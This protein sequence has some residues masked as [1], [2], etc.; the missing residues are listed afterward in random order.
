MITPL[1]HRLEQE[2]GRLAQVR[3]DKASTS[4]SLDNLRAERQR[5]ERAAAIIS[6]V[7]LATQQELEFR[8]SDLVTMAL[9]VIPFDEDY[10]FVVEFV[11]RRG[12]TECDLFLVGQSGNRVRILDASGGGVANVVALALRVSLWSLSKG[13]RPTLVLDE[14][15]PFLRTK[16]AHAK[17]GEL[18]KTIS[19]K[20]GL[21][22]IMIT[23]EAESQDII[24][25]ADRV[26][27][28]SKVKGKTIIEGQQ[29]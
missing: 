16:E 8:I 10:R 25:N 13:I 2:K 29:G 22:I 11:Q 12:R 18:L 19:E 3:A 23:G 9:E 26:F 27:R 5:I 24:E 1:R 20:L 17:A 6:M 4:S 7:G 21:Q 14:P 15:F 28:F